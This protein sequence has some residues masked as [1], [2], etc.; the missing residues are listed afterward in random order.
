M[1]S[2]IKQLLLEADAIEGTLEYPSDMTPESYQA[3]LADINA[4]AQAIEERFDNVYTKKRQGQ[5][6]SFLIRLSV[7]NLPK[8][9]VGTLDN[10]IGSIVFSAFGNLALISESTPLSKW[11][12]DF[13]LEQLE[14]YGFVHIPKEDVVNVPYDGEKYRG[15]F[16][17]K[18]TWYTRF[19]DFL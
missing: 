3:I 8:K 18:F 5:S 11:Q 13:M 7:L 15:R 19:F 4:I 2:R 10:M 6:S 14:T 16:S 9:T 1:N 12:F 17:E